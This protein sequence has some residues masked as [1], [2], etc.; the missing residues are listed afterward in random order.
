MIY[1]A[2][3]ILLAAHSKYMQSNRIWH[4]VARKLTGDATL[5][6]LQEL[7]QHLIADPELAA[8]VEM[9]LAYFE[10]EPAI[11]PSTI[12]KNWQQQLFRLKQEFPEDFHSPSTEQEEK[13]VT[14]IQVKNN[15]KAWYVIAA[16]LLVGL[17]ITALWNVYYK[18]SNNDIVIV[19]HSAEGKHASHKQVKLPDGSLVWL[20]KNSHLSYNKGFGV[21]NREIT[22][23][24]E[25]F[26]DVAHKA[27]LPMVVHAGLVNIK[28]KGTA[29]NVNAYQDADRVETSLIRGVVE[30][31]VKGNPSKAIMMKPNEKVVVALD[32][33]E[34]RLT[35]PD[36]AL[37][38]LSID[39][40]ATESKS[41]LI[42][43]LA[44]VENKLVFNNLPFPEVK[45]KLERWYDIKIKIENEKIAKER[46]TAVLSSESLETFLK[47][48]QMTYNFK[49]SI[50]NE[51][52]TIY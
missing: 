7:E 23:S 12:E 6:E 40:L 33:A 15:F 35:T 30:L 49:Y 25:A 22:L 18:K 20:N 38:N 16:M 9:H 32:S 29:F 1:A 34:K 11:S 43:E 50:S 37:V 4:L 8:S 13:Q 19:D 26:F 31:S 41:G 21:D 27:E 10:K 3:G 48:L 45:D 47:A 2:I 44:W 39:Q 52:V 36:R 42:P 51:I 24:G 5:E 46:F 28:V 17:T 14:V